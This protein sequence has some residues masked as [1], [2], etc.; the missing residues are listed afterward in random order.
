MIKLVYPPVGIVVLDTDNPRGYLLHH[1]QFYRLK[2]YHRLNIG[3]PFCTGAYWA[4]VFI[5]NKIEEF[6]I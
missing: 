5:A 2:S 3:M 6:S 1:F 4:Y